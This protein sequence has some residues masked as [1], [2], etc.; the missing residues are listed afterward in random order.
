MRALTHRTSLADLGATLTRL[1]QIQRGWANYFRH[2]VATA[3]V[4]TPPAV[5]LVADRA[6]AQDAEPLAVDRSSQACDRP[7]RPV[8]T[9][10]RRRGHAVQPREGRHHP[11]P[12]PRRSHPQPLDRPITTSVTVESPLRREAYGGFGERPG[13]TGRWQHRNRAPG[14][15][16]LWAFADHGQ[17]G[18]GEP[19]AVLLRPGNAGSNTASDHIAVLKEALR[20]LPGHHSG[21]RPG[22]KVLVRIDGA[23]ATYQV[24]DWLTAQRLSYSVG[25]GL[26]ANTAKL[27]ALLP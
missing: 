25:Y 18:T 2:A 20:Q 4:Q 3:H 1:N 8:E 19:L 16:S 15:L 11:L 17:D 24:L 12:L 22:R 10:Q 27:L 7:H 26:P 6:L 13:E 21:R 5:S 14:R 23:G 9:D